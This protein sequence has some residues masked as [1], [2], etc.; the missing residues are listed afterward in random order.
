MHRNAVSPPHGLNSSITD[1][2]L[3]AAKVQLSLLENPSNIDRLDGNKS[4]QFSIGP[5]NV[6]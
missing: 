6:G 5:L 3:L 4:T 2:I 1:T